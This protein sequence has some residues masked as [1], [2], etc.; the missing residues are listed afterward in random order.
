MEKL[1]NM[2]TALRDGMI[3]NPGFC[4][5][6]VV[7]VENAI[8][9]LFGADSLEGATNL[10]PLQKSVLKETMKSLSA[11]TTAQRILE[12]DK[13]PTASIVP[14]ILYKTC[15]DFGGKSVYQTPVCPVTKNC[16]TIAPQP[17]PATVCSP[18]R[19]HC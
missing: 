1:M 5:A 6:V 8:D 7:D 2:Q 14:N 12:G 18:D 15:Y 10:S 17:S 11:M 3:P 4:N 13:Y 19:H 9:G 16:F